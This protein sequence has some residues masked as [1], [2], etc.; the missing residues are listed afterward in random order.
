MHAC[1]PHGIETGEQ[2]D[3]HARAWADRSRKIHLEK[4]WP[5]INASNVLVAKSVSGQGLD[6]LRNGANRKFRD[7]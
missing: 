5:S 1:I 3:F 2:C 7:E 6:R 4:A